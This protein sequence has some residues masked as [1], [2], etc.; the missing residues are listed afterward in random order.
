MYAIASRGSL[1]LLL[2]T[3]GLAILRGRSND[4]SKSRRQLGRDFKLIHALHPHINPAIS[5]GTS[6]QEP[7]SGFGVATKRPVRPIR[8]RLAELPTVFLPVRAHMAHIIIRD[9]SWYA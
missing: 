1:L 2:K 3:N 6:S 4:D 7:V 8:H 9:P 5:L